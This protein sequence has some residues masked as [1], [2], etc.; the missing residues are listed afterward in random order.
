MMG[1]KDQTGGSGNNA[2]GSNDTTAAETSGGNKSHPD[3]Q[4]TLRQR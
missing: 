3:L 4:P 1:G 2:Q